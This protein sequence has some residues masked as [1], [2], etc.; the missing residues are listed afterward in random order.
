MYDPMDTDQIMREAALGQKDNPMAPPEDSSN[1]NNIMITRD[2]LYLRVQA[3]ERHIAEDSIEHSQYIVQQTLQHLS[4][5]F[6]S[7]HI[8][9]ETVRA[10]YEL[11]QEI[12][13]ELLNI[14]INK[15]VLM[16]LT[17]ELLI[18]VDPC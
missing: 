17:G 12:A 14:P 15:G 18:R 16:Q 5:P 8:P 6:A 10:L 11:F 1:E 7:R 2:I 3:L 4:S 13:V 9:D